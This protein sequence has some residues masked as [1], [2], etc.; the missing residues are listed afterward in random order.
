MLREQTVHVKIATMDLS[1]T[2]FALVVET[3]QMVPAI[4]VLM[5]A[6]EITVMNQDALV[7]TALI[8][9][10]MEAVS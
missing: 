8:A 9:Q 1:A 5:E 10:D 2:S 4:V 7:F 3:V 6:E